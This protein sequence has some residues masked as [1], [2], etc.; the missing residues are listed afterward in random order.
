MPK[1]LKLLR[2]SKIDFRREL[3]ELLPASHMMHLRDF[4]KI[5]EH[6]IEEYIGKQKR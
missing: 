4:K 1:V 2:D 3:K 5:L 6:K